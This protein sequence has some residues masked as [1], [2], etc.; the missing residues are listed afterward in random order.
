MSGNIHVDDGFT[1]ESASLES[2]S[3]NVRMFSEVKKELNAETTSGRILLS[4][5]RSGGITVKSTAGKIQLTDVIAEKNLYVKSISGGVMLDE[6]DGSTIKIETTSGSVKGTILSDKIFITD[7]ISGRV[8]VPR[9]SVGG[10][11]E[12]TTISGNI[13]IELKAIVKD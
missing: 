4:H 7:S 10:E 5:I 2:V 3:G 11:C 1:F 12:V 8:K 6:C 13:T 9:S